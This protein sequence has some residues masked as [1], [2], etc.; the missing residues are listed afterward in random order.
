VTG[1]RR[2]AAVER[3]KRPRV[4]LVDPDSL[5][6]ET[7]EALRLRARAAAADEQK[8]KSADALYLTYLEE[9]RRALDPQQE[10]K[11]I[12]LDLAGHSDR[13]RLDGTIFFHGITYGVP[14][15][16][17]ESLRET[18][19]RGWKHEFEVGGANRN[20]YQRPLDTQLNGRTK[21]VTNRGLMMGAR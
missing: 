21:A 14:R 20:A 5:D 12:Q 16:V 7:K 3:V 13:I 4:N 1:E 17:F 6:A 19:Q 15:A 11:Y 10:T 8:Q 2:M 18:V 9:E